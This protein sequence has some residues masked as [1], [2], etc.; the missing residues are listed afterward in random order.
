MHKDIVMIKEIQV[1]KLYV[2]ACQFLGLDPTGQYSALLRISDD[3]FRWVTD[4]VV[5]GA[6]N[7]FDG[8][9]IH[10]YYTYMPVQ[11]HTDTF[12]REMLIN[13]EKTVYQLINEIAFK[14]YVDFPLGYTLYARDETGEFPLDLALTVPEQVLDFDKMTF[15]RRALLFTKDDIISPYTSEQLYPDVV[16]SVLS[17]IPDVN[18]NNAIELAVYHALT[19][20]P[21][22]EEAAN[23][24]IDNIAELLPSN[25]KLKHKI[26]NKIKELIT[27][28]S[29]QFLQH[30]AI[31]KYIFTAR[32]LNHFG[33][34]IY[35]GKLEEKSEVDSKS[36]K[37]QKKL[38][39]VNIAIGPFR[40]TVELTFNDENGIYC[41]IEIESEE[42][43]REIY[44]F[45]NDLIE[46]L[47]MPEFRDF[48]NFL[49]IALDDI[50]EGYDDIL[51]M[52]DRNALLNDTDVNPA[53]SFDDLNTQ[54]DDKLFNKKE[55]NI[56]WRL[57]SDALMYKRGDGLLDALLDQLN[58]MS[59][60]LNTS[61]PNDLYGQLNFLHDQLKQY[62]DGCDDETK[63]IFLP[64]LDSLDSLRKRFQ[65]IAG[66][67]LDITPYIGEIRSKIN[68]LKAAIEPA[69]KKLELALSSL[70]IKLRNSFVS[71]DAGSVI[72]VRVSPLREDQCLANALLNISDLQEIL[73]TQLQKNYPLYAKFLDNPNQLTKQLLMSSS[74]LT[75]IASNL[76]KAN[77]NPEMMRKHLI[78]QL[79]DILKQLNA[80]G[81]VITKAK[82]KGINIPEIENLYHD[83]IGKI[84]SLLKSDVLNN[85]K[86]DRTTQF[87]QFYPGDHRL[88]EKAIQILQNNVIT[89]SQLMNDQQIASNKSITSYLR[90][91]VEELDHDSQS[92][93]IAFEN[94]NIDALND[95]NRTQAIE[96]LQNTLQNY[97]LLEQQFSKM[98]NV[99]LGLTSFIQK[100]QQDVPELTKILYS[101]ST[102]NITPQN[103]QRVSDDLTTIWNRY[104]SLPPEIILKLTDNQR[105]SLGHSVGK[106]KDV[107][108]TI[109][110]ILPNFMNNPTS[111]QCVYSAQQSILKVHDLLPEIH[112][113]VNQL[114]DITNDPTYPVLYERLITNVKSTLSEQPLSEEFSHL[115]HLKKFQQLQGETA[116]VLNLMAIS[117]ENPYIKINKELHEKLEFQ[118]TQ[119]KTNYLTQVQT[120]DE[121]HERPFAN[122]NILSAVNVVNKL[123]QIVERIQPTSRKVSDLTNNLQLEQMTNHLLTS[124]IDALNAIRKAK[125]EP[126]RRLPTQNMVN[127]LEKAL[128]G[129][130]QSLQELE[131]LPEISQNENLK[132]IFG[133]YITLN[134]EIDKELR[135]MATKPNM[136]LYKLASKLEKELIQITP[137]LSQV[138]AFKANKKHQDRLNE[139]SNVLGETLQEIIPTF[140]DCK[141]LIRNYVPI[142][143]ECS[144]VFK[145]H[146]NNPKVKQNQI[147]STILND[148]V[149]N[150]ITS[151]N[152]LMEHLND[153]KYGI[154]HA[155][156]DKNI[157][158]KLLDKY[159]Q[160]PPDLRQCLTPK[161]IEDLAKL[162]GR[163]AESAHNAINGIRQLPGLK[164]PKSD[165]SQF[166]KIEAIEELS[167]SI[168]KLGK[169]IESLRQF[170]KELVDTN[171]LYDRP[172]ALKLTTEIEQQLGLV[173][174]DQFKPDA[175]ENQLM[176]TLSDLKEK[177]NFVISSSELISPII[178][179]PYIGRNT[180]IVND[181]INTILHIL[182]NPHLNLNTSKEFVDTVLPMLKKIQPQ[183]HEFIKRQDVLSN[184]AL[185]DYSKTLD[186]TIDKSIVILPE[187]IDKPRKLQMTL[188]EL[189]QSTS[190]LIPLLQ[191]NPDHESYLQ[192]V[193]KLFDLLNDYTSLQKVEIRYSDAIKLKKPILSDKQVK[194]LADQTF[195]AFESRNNEVEPEL[196]ENLTD[197]LGFINDHQEQVPVYISHAALLI[198]PSMQTHEL[199][200]LSDSLRTVISC[201][202][203]G[204]ANDLYEKLAVKTSVRAALQLIQLEKS[205]EFLEQR[206]EQFSNMFDD[207]TK[208]YLAKL[209]NAIKRSDTSLILQ[210]QSLPTAVFNYQPLHNIDD[211]LQLL[212]KKVSN[213]AAI[214]P[215][216]QPLQD[217]GKD[218]SDWVFQTDL[219]MMAY[220]QN[221]IDDIVS[222]T[223]DLIS[224]DKSHKLPA[225]LSGFVRQAVS[226]LKFK[227]RGISYDMPTIKQL[228]NLIINYQSDLYP[229]ILKALPESDDTKQLQNHIQALEKIKPIIKYWQSP[230]Q[231]LT[232]QGLR[233]NVI[234]SLCTSIKSTNNIK[235]T[236]ENNP[237]EIPLDFALGSAKISSLLQNL[238][239]AID[240]NIPVKEVHEKSIKSSELAK[241]II[242]SKNP[243]QTKIDIESLINCLTQSEELIN[244]VIP[245]DYNSIDEIDKISDLESLFSMISDKEALNLV[246]EAAKYLEKLI[247]SIPKLSNEQRSSDTNK[248]NTK[249]DIKLSNGKT[250]QLPKHSLH[251]SNIDQSLNDPIISVDPKE[252]D[253]LLNKLED[254][255]YLTDEPTTD[256]QNSTIAQIERTMLS[257]RISQLQQQQISEF[258]DVVKNISSINS[259]VLPITNITSDQA[260]SSINSIQQQ[261]EA[262]Q[263]SSE[264]H[265]LQSRLSPDQI[266]SQQLLLTHNLTQAIDRNVDLPIQSHVEQTNAIQQQ[267]FKSIMDKLQTG[268]LPNTSIKSDDLSASIQRG[269]SQLALINELITIQQQ[270]SVNI[271]DLFKFVQSPEGL[272][273]LSSPITPHQLL[274][275][276]QNILKQVNLV[277]S[278]ELLNAFQKN[279]LPEQ[280][281][282]Q[283]RILQHSLKLLTGEFG[284]SL[285][286]SESGK[287][288]VS[289]TAIFASLNSL[290]Q[291]IIKENP[292]VLKLNYYVNPSDILEAQQFS[293]DLLNRLT[294]MQKISDIQQKQLTTNKNAAQII[295]KLNQPT[296]SNILNARQISMQSKSLITQF[297]D[298]T[299]IL[300]LTQQLSAQE[301]LEQQQIL[302]A[303]KSILT[304]PELLN[305]YCPGI[306][307][308][309]DLNSKMNQ[310]FNQLQD[311]Q[312]N[313]L[314]KTTKPLD[315][316]K[317]LI[318]SQIMNGYEKTNSK[319]TNLNRIEQVKTLL[320]TFN[321]ITPDLSKQ[322]LTAKPTFSSEQLETTRAILERL[323]ELSSS[324]LSN[325]TD[326]INN[327]TK[328][329]QKR[330]YSL[331]VKEVSK[332]NKFDPYIAELLQKQSRIFDMAA[333]IQRQPGI[334]IVSVSTKDLPQIE[335]A[336]QIEKKVKSLQENIIVK[337]VQ[338]KLIKLMEARND[339]NPMLASITDEDKNNALKN[340]TANDVPKFS[341]SLI[342]QVKVLNDNSKLNNILEHTNKDQLIVE[343]V[344][345]QQI[346]TDE[347]K[348]SKDAKLNGIK[349]VNVTN[350]LQTTIIKSTEQ[351]IEHQK[352]TLVSSIQVLTPIKPLTNTKIKTASKLSDEQFART[353]L[354]EK[355]E[356][357][358]LKQL[359]GIKGLDEFVHNTSTYE[360]ATSDP[361]TQD[362][363]IDYQD[364]L[365]SLITIDAKAEDVLQ[366]YQ[367][368][369]K[370]TNTRG[371]TVLTNLTDTIT[372][373]DINIVTELEKDNLTD[374][375]KSFFDKS[376]NYDDLIIGQVM[377]VKIPSEKQNASRVASAYQGLI[378]IV[379]TMYNIPSEE[380]KSIL[381]AENKEALNIVN[382]IYDSKSTSYSNQIRKLV[383]IAPQLVAS[384]SRVSSSL[385]PQVKS[386]LKLN[387]LNIMSSIEALQNASC[388]KSTQ[389]TASNF[390]KL[391]ADLYSTFQNIDSA[392]VENKDENPI[393]STVNCFAS[394]AKAIQNQDIDLMNK[395][396]IQFKGLNIHSLSFGTN[397]S[398]L[399]AMEPKINKIL[400]LVEKSYAIHGKIS[401]ELLK[402]LTELRTDL[403]TIINKETKNP[404]ELIEKL[405]TATDV[406]KVISNSM[407]KIGVSTKNLIESVQNRNKSSKT[408]A[409]AEIIEYVSNSIAAIFQGL[410]VTSCENDSIYNDCIRIFDSSL[411]SVRSMI[412]ILKTSAVSSTSIRRSTRSF[413]RM[414]D[415]ML[416]IMEDTNIPI[417]KQKAYIRYR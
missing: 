405:K 362:E 106:I 1:K 239:D 386:Q 415:S 79:N 147:A 2:K 161:E 198:T 16:R 306:N 19:L 64:L 10:L 26:F 380:V 110:K 372:P 136:N 140:E 227:E 228:S 204:L 398:Y 18:D 413:N 387:P 59:D 130:Q 57:L 156:E 9:T 69:K 322:I 68:E 230:I 303:I 114:S 189:Y 329:D 311:Q 21:S 185:L 116:R 214:K 412:D 50:N 326:L 403:I 256:K 202:S 345:L 334:G 70:D 137:T 96:A 181:N 38:L 86:Q 97:Q 263:S 233:S 333:I 394:M 284:Q 66:N 155:T 47:N 89:S 250:M 95:G 235:N 125:C 298:P 63:Q 61:D 126:F 262:L 32:M 52:L 192:A 205:L 363:V 87:Y 152:V 268:N 31:M 22:P 399:K 179:D 255:I 121:L 376:I 36:A 163:L 267:L 217:C 201:S 215:I 17:G 331:L 171:T 259:K 300:Q 212:L 276:Q 207:E 366:T 176:K 82:E 35:S 43:S 252:Y 346:I 80:V 143:N 355:L 51:N 396:I 28:Y 44:S 389:E 378:T 360:T 297:N 104:A 330:V 253:E 273:L 221:H 72:P 164:R 160:I 353:C 401:P 159:A 373:K 379:P 78:P 5:L 196:F 226:N 109:D 220:F 162:L 374:E 310:L 406:Q 249:L 11:I 321:T 131:K 118:A 308:S 392:I 49:D 56:D 247:A 234:S 184:Q 62:L 314:R 357:I 20:Y 224:K 282:I 129:F 128:D 409:I 365:K 309:I 231:N 122:E 145:G 100:L 157:M 324:N 344:M 142:L 139:L 277:S 411:I 279:L 347:S 289:K 188:D 275:Q 98:S 350:S 377:D 358:K 83:L 65:D 417:Y 368:Q 25:Y 54:Y 400:P 241:S 304:N 338:N 94:L 318:D 174:I 146:L 91:K 186:T 200:R 264:L 149:D 218:F 180:R 144:N 375:L 278:P 93:Q 182:E 90:P 291:E 127:A 384:Y 414:F 175:D 316:I 120:R 356:N 285:M 6:L 305:K 92:L 14:M 296:N 232:N 341:S 112:S 141:N 81:N 242:D 229:Q 315:G 191:E 12:D 154:Q 190:L 119:L 270:L 354:T 295:P 274:E 404:Y 271:P 67:D 337:G 105:T 55:D 402:S 4:D 352:P 371:L 30:Q 153:P 323:I 390:R 74:T 37:K 219:S 393:S 281:I 208:F 348:E 187:S 335:K 407:Q 123:Q 15:R 193:N 349:L 107:L 288:D 178:H 290:Q 135:A 213:I 238:T 166:A 167:E 325:V 257:Q 251:S 293:Y 3:D 244:K 150:A 103:V 58:I 113:F 254:L 84:E 211:S 286:S 216:V 313:L 75:Q 351:A 133:K 8:V 294:C 312:N 165:P 248:F 39:R 60:G 53:D 280:I 102:V 287:D 203:E 71:T 101:L 336:D 237:E 88:L 170:Y 301:L 364:M 77:G 246:K 169:Q 332:L 397:D 367:K 42:H 317:P 383:E 410:N 416:D 13:V 369:T 385:K 124:A 382:Q 343:Q 272:Q 206:V 299:K 29:G 381:I 99:P 115:N 340:I 408:Q 108:N 24:Q 258:P 302:S 359:K 339:L 223:E 132:S 138:Q 151:Y 391:L 73:V 134:D 319:L 76:L 320:K 283:Q 197:N 361:F 225:A 33:C 199:V 209:Q 395:E 172:N 7:P 260:S 158:L 327:L 245:I 41:D 269:Y 342:Q 23:I 148:W 117:S 111:G 243:S 292:E 34:E 236:N 48:P 307:K 261:F 266:L 222:K 173:K 265:K 46:L 370:E 240:K 85:Y 183:S 328:D 168:P 27:S 388:V 177:M 195:S 210:C 45:I 40:Y 194:E